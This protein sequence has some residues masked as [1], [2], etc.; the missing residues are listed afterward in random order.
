M[1]GGNVSKIVGIWVRGL[2]TELGDK[3]G[4]TATDGLSGFQ[5]S[6]RFHWPG[7]RESAGGGH[8]STYLKSHPNR[9]AFT[10]SLHLKSLRC[11]ENYGGLRIVGMDF[12]EI[13]R[14]RVILVCFFFIILFR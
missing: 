6:C 3:H 7:G 12:S 8:D 2:R 1:I 11:E 10:L 13:I 4:G 5:L 9:T 14:F